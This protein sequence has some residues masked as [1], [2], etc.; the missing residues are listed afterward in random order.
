MTVPSQMSVRRIPEALHLKVRV[1]YAAA[2]EALIGTHTDQ[3][4]QFV[5]EF[6]PRLPVLDGL[7][8]YFQV[9]AVPEAMQETVRFHT[10]T[11]L[12]L[13]SLPPLTP[14]PAL[15]GWRLLRIDLLL[16]QQRY[17]RRY[18]EKTLELARMV[19]ARA[20]EAVVATHVENAIG[21]AQLLKG[22]LPVNAATDRY[23]RE[24]GLPANVAQ[25]V[26]QR[27]QARVAGDELTAQYDDLP[28]RQIEP[29]GQSPRRADTA[30]DPAPAGEP[31]TA[32]D[33]ASA[34]PAFPRPIARIL[35]R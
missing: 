19:G 8:L 1:A 26:M 22:A 32:P 10:L 5:C 27:V 20:A 2:W 7:D 4:L 3:A 34:S 6:A 11:A 21:F 25:M 30:P 33:P 15:A 18:H 28:P 29:A 14:L 9:T 17:R 16:E 35:T 23:L 31:A 12:D 13:E 24:F